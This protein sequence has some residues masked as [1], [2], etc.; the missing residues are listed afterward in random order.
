M[1]EAPSSRPEA[2]ESRPA[3]SVTWFCPPFGA[4]ASSTSATMPMPIAIQP[5]TLRPWPVTAAMATG[6]TDW[7]SAMSG[8]SRL[9]GPIA[10]TP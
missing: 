7:M 1:S 5:T 2:T 10:S 4:G 6:T 8:E 3:R 9:I